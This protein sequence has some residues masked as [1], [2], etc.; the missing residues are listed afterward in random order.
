MSASNNAMQAKLAAPS[1]QPY[2]IA[3]NA[4]HGAVGPIGMPG[5]AG[6]LGF[7]GPPAPMVFEDLLDPLADVIARNKLRMAAGAAVLEYLEAQVRMEL[8]K[9]SPDQRMIF[10]QAIAVAVEQI[11]RPNIKIRNP[12]EKR[13][14]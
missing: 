5:P 7:P 12:Y 9:D 3:P 14:D 8:F 6:H 13:D 10:E 4:V 2:M 11:V 1:A